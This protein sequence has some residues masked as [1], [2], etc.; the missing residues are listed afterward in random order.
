MRGTNESGECTRW[1][2]PGRHASRQRYYLI[3]LNKTGTTSVRRLAELGGMKVSD[4]RL[5]ELVL[6]ARGVRYER[7]NDLLNSADFFQDVPFS[8]P[9]VFYWIEQHDPKAK[10][11]LTLRRSPEAWAESVAQFYSRFAGIRREDARWHHLSKSRYRRVGYI[12]DLM[13]QL[14][15]DSKVPFDTTSLVETYRNHEEA[16]THHFGSDPDRLL[17]V[18]I[19]SEKALEMLV[20]FLDLQNAGIS[21]LPHLNSGM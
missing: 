13:K 6:G 3:G 9:K 20:D 2:P 19:E 8:L 10:F 12:H 7:L 1:A 4:Q 17:V 14:A 5:G 18:N 16:V 21:S 11:I 15:V